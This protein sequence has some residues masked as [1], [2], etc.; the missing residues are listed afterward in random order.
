MKREKNVLGLENDF[1]H[2]ASPLCNPPLKLCDMALY[3][4]RQIVLPA[5]RTKNSPGIFI[6]VPCQWDR[7][8]KITKPSQ[9]VKP[10]S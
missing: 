5:R 4:R 3:R 2:S 6:L 10:Y 8:T 7:T 1:R 9:L